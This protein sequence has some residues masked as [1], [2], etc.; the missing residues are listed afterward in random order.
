MYEHKLKVND[1]IPFRSPRYSIPIAYREKGEQEITRMLE[2]GIIR[3]S[4]SAWVNPMVVTPK[5]DG[6]VR[7]FLDAG[8]LS[9]RMEE[10]RECP[11]NIEEI[12]QRCTGVKVMSSFDLTSSFWQI[13]L[14]ESSKK[15]TAFLHQGKCYEYN[16]TPFGLKTSSA[17]LIRG[18][19]RVLDGEDDDV[20]NFVDDLLCVSKSSEEHLEKIEKML[21][22]LKDG[23]MTIGFKKS[24]MFRKEITFLGHVLNTEGIK[25]EPGKIEGIKQFPRP[26]RLRQLRGFLGLMD[27]Y[28][29]FARRYAHV[30]APLMELLRK[31]AKWTWNHEKEAAFIKAKDLFC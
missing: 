30:T 14:E 27:F 24:K 25:P 29:K 4:S 8:R 26:R 3:Q 5:K 21:K 16:V 2:V 22:K 31:G 10:D 17:A 19:D 7:V 23:A 6:S 11:Q 1:K 15:F 12:F 9:Q 13:P 28:S 18:L 20:L